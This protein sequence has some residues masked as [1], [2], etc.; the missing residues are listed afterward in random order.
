MKLSVKKTKCMAIAMEPSRYKLV[1]N[2][3][4]M[5]QVIQF[6][7]LGIL[8]TSSGISAIEVKE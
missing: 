8:I 3:H 4:L 7:H 5:E 2:T 6:K 1:V